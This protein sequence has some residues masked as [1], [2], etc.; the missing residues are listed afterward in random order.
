M[1]EN[2]DATWH[3]RRQSWQ[4]TRLPFKKTGPCTGAADR[5]HRIGQASS[6]NVYFLHARGSIDD[7]IWQSIQVGGAFGSMLEKTKTE[8]MS[9][10]Q[11]G[12]RVATC[13]L[14]AVPAS[15]HSEII[16]VVALQVQH[17]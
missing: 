11:V 8:T 13:A 7:L 10:L 5:A 9:H 15:I 14:P 12:L 17:P 16:R 1:L 2:A 3:G 6:V 4:G